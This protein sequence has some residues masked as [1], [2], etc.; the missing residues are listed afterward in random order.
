MKNVQESLKRSKKMKEHIYQSG[1]WLSKWV[2]EDC[3]KPA[4]LRDTSRGRIIYKCSEH[5]EQYV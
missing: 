3:G 2:C 1:S 5:I 4:M